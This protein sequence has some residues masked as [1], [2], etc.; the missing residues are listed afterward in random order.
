MYQVKWQIST[1]VIQDHI[2]YIFWEQ[3]VLLYKGEP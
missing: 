1:F 3:Y 2:E